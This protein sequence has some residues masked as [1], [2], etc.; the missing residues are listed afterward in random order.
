MHR[1]LS[2]KYIFSRNDSSSEKMYLKLILKNKRVVLLSY[3]LLSEET[4]FWYDCWL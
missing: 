2:F 3:I 1:L 4:F